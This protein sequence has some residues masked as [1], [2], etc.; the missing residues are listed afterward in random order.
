MITPIVL[1]FRCQTTLILRLNRP[2]SAM[3]EIFSGGTPFVF[4]SEDGLSRS[5]V[6]SPAVSSE[7]SHRILIVEDESLIGWS[8]A[9]ALRKAGFHCDVVDCGEIA[10]QKI[11]EVPFDLIISD[12]RLPR[13]NGL[14]LAERVKSH[15]ETT[16]VMIVSAGE[17]VGH[18]DLESD[19]RIDYFLEKPF[20]L[21]DMVARV[22]EILERADHHK[23]HV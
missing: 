10:M 7:R 5:Y 8:M 19:N 15:S 4:T 17:D 14:D 13:M 2:F 23:N 20:N 16:P 21:K 11:Q 18:G 12:I 1:V 6:F 9:N 3:R 22:H